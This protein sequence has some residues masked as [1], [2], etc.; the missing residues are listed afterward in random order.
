MPLIMKGHEVI[1]TLN[2]FKFVGGAG[3]IEA[4]GKTET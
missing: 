4:E 1:L 3:C 2:V